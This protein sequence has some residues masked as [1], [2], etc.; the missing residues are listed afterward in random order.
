VK[1]GSGT[2]AH[3]K[4]SIDTLSA[5]TDLSPRTVRRAVRELVAL[6]VLSYAP[7]DEFYIHLDVLDA[8]PRI[9]GDGA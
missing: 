5:A 8:M 2:A 6:G 1:V 9:G 4:V 7:P 3:A